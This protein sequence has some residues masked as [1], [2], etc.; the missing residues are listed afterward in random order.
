MYR[1]NVFNGFPYLS[2]RF[3]EFFRIS[4]P[5]DNRIND[6]NKCIRGK[7]KYL[8]NRKK[9]EKEIYSLSEAYPDISNVR[10]CNT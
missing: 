4:T 8:K 1:L 9:L 5:S 7:R 3:C 2:S 6:L 10:E